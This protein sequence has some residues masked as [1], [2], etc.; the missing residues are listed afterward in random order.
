MT[1]HNCQCIDCRI[2]RRQK[3]LQRRE[4][5]GPSRYPPEIRRM[6]EPLN[7]P[8][9]WVLRRKYTNEDLD[10]TIKRYIEKM[11]RKEKRHA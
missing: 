10:R 8:G 7:V 4:V 11:R 3:A 6:F 9:L 1:N 2:R 5:P